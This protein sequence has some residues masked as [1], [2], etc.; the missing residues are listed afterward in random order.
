[1]THRLNQVLAIEKG[2]KARVFGEI[3][4]LHN[5]VQRASIL[6]GFSKTYQPKDDEGDRYPP[7]RQRVQLIA[8]DMLR[9]AGRLLSELFDVT[10]SK[11]WANTRARADVV[12][13]GE[14]LLEQVPATFLLF[15]EK[16]LGDLRTLIGK[17]P[18]LD[19]ADDWSLDE[20]S[21]LYKTQSTETSRTKKVQRPI[22]LYPATTE[23]PAQ[24]QLI[25]EDQVVGTWVTVKHS[26]ALPESRKIQL[27]DRIERLSNAV[28]FA[29]EQ[30]NAVEAV[31]Q[32]VG[33]RVFRYLL[34]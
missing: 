32:E 22:V 1:M 25:S 5:A 29:R 19:Q 13:D 26:G 10:A 6:N 15:V 9:K 17:V 28:K 31:R 2:T 4:K 33:E 21:Q 24:T 23:H 14:V 30:A 16:Q 34:Q 27:L 11:D 8:S 20:G 7:E 12:V 3:S 18:V